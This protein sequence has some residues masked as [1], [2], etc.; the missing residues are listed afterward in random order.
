MKDEYG[1]N[2]Y[3]TVNNLPR[4]MLNEI[5]V[6]NGWT[7]NGSRYGDFRL[8]NNW[9]DLELYG[10]DE[11]KVFLNGEL[12]NPIDSFKLLTELLR[13]NKVNFSAGLYDEKEEIIIIDKNIST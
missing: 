11:T 4:T 13:E 2:F 6:K 12:I 10:D 5:L 1:N 7:S 3:C 9:S 8:K